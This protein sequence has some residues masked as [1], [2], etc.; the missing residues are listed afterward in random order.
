MGKHERQLIEEAEKIIGKLLTS[1]K[2]TNSEEKNRWANHAVRI[3]EKIKRDFRKISSVRHLGNR[4]ED[5]GD[6]SI[7][8]RG[9]KKIIELKMSDTKLGT[10]TKANISQNA[11]TDCKLFRN[12]VKS[13][14][15]F[16]E[17]KNHKNWVNA[18]LNQFD[19]YPGKIE[20]IKNSINKKEEKARYLRKLAK[21]RNKKAKGLLKEIWQRDREEKM[22]YLDYLRKK[23][24]RPEIIKKFFILIK[25]GIHKKDILEDLIN[26]DSFFQE[27]QNFFIYYANLD[28]NKIIVRREDVG[29]KIRDILEKYVKFEITFPNNVTHCKLMGIDNNKKK[30]P[31]LQIVFHWKNIAQGIKTP[32][33]NIF[34]LTF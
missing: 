23:K 11:L 16:R 10:G 21:K 3:A 18:L 5:A 12:N 33:L 4:Y 32:C 6:I 8:S 17:E 24:Q 9:E 2:L 15:L 25:L 26:K 29:K 31:L 19:K 27:V 14:S 30:T 22:E 34:D 28:K 1:Q 13:W 20:K 7:I